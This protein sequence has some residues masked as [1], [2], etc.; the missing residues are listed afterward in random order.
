MEVEIWDSK[1]SGCLCSLPIKGEEKNII[2]GKT[3]EIRDMNFL[4]LW[5]YQN[6][7][8]SYGKN[9]KPIKP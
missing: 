2:V 9:F 1:P 4:N 7:A 5:N 3:C 6:P 8:I